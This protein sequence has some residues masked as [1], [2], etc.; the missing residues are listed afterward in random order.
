[1]DYLGLSDSAFKWNEFELNDFE[2]AINDAQRASVR[3]FWERHFPLAM[4]VRDDHSYIAV[5]I[6]QENAGQL[7]L[8]ENSDE[9][10]IELLA[11]NFAD[12]V[13]LVEDFYSGNRTPPLSRLL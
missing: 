10:E 2:F 12:F 3:Q 9:N 8:G 6:D 11:D 5:G 7:F 1:M 13:D 4:S